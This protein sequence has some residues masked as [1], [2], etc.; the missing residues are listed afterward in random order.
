MS[1]RL[2]IRVHPT[3]SQQGG[4]SRRSSGI[5]RSPAWAFGCT[6][7]AGDRGGLRYRVNGRRRI[8]TLGPFGVLTLTEARDDA[9]ARLVDLRQTREDPLAKPATVPTVSEVGIQY[10]EDRRTRVQVVY[11]RVLP[12]QARDARR[13][14]CPVTGGLHRGPR[15]VPS[16][17]LSGQ[18]PRVLL[19][20]I[21]HCD[22]SGHSLTSRWRGASERLRVRTQPP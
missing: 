18:R 20:R 17:R 16:L 9:K 15:R 6:R 10:L 22:C 3:V 14:A 5:R 21:R 11:P 1:K 4:Q 12:D 2:C 8:V 7:L 13:E 19:Q